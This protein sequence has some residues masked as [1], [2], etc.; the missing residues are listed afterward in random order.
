M[1]SG[2][3]EV[4]GPRFYTPMIR[5]RIYFKMCSKRIHAL[6]T[7]VKSAMNSNDWAFILGQLLASHKYTKAQA[8]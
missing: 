2:D 5:E 4:V 7:N 6:D 8:V 3:K 1:C